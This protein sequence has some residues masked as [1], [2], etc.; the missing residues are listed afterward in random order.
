MLRKR[1]WNSNTF[2]TYSEYIKVLLI[3]GQ[4][5]VLQNNIVR[6]H[7]HHNIF[8]ILRLEHIS[9]IATLFKHIQ[10]TIATHCGV[11]FMLLMKRSR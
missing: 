10:N 2:Q 6:R 11:V 5:V 4:S 8:K 9:G 7:F 1:F 3:L